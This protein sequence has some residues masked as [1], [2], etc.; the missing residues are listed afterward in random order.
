MV[1]ERRILAQVTVTGDRPYPAQDS[2][3]PARFGATSLPPRR[4]DQKRFARI[5]PDR[6]L[7]NMLLIYNI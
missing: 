3:P 5:N 2:H 6:D 7:Q 4:L 1:F